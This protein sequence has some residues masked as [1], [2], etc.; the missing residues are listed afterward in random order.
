M[1]FQLIELNL[2]L[3]TWNRPNIN[4]FLIIT[5][6]LSNL[7]YYRIGALWPHFKHTTYILASVYWHSGNLSIR[8]HDVR[9]YIVSSRRAFELHKIV[10][11]IETLNFNMKLNEVFTLA[12]TG[13]I[14][15]LIENPECENFSIKNA[16]IENFV[17]YLI[18][19]NYIIEIPQSINFG[20]NL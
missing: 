14:L 8:I 16:Q 20:K 4:W 7:L 5:I 13:G 10:T 9:T 15:T 3:E 6:L 1:I 17:V 12:R 18:R 19:Y 2:K 11:I